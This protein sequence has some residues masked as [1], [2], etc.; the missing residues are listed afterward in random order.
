[1]TKVQIDLPDSVLADWLQA[2]LSKGINLEE[3]LAGALTHTS[4]NS[5]SIASSLNISR[6]S[7]EEL[8]RRRPGPEE[9]SAAYDRGD[10]MAKKTDSTQSKLDEPHIAE[11]QFRELG[12]SKI[13]RRITTNEAN[14]YQDNQHIPSS[15]LRLLPVKIA[16]RAISMKTDRSGNI[17]DSEARFSVEKAL[18]TTLSELKSGAS[19]LIPTKNSGLTAGMGSNT[20]IARAR[21]INDLLGAKGRAGGLMHRL[22]I[23]EQSSTQH[24]LTSEGLALAKQRNPV[25]DGD[26]QQALTRRES[27]AILLLIEQRIPN[28]WKLMSTIAKVAAGSEPKPKTKSKPLA[29]ENVEEKATIEAGG[30]GP[31][32]AIGE[33][34]ETE[35]DSVKLKS[36]QKSAANHAA[37]LAKDL[38]S[39]AEIDEIIIQ[40]SSNESK[41]WTEAKLRT[42]RVALLGRMT[43]LGLLERV[44]VGRTSLFRPGRNNIRLI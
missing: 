2:A 41:E 39:T 14:S 44:W 8:H 30:Q 25:L 21:L 24:R 5:S 37:E 26:A 22:G 6:M 34:S 19:S 33:E 31:E 36:N 13:P 18:K 7:N 38:L 32:E 9:I 27:K 17:N 43:E 1:M 10:S 3:L 23:L 11:Q 28:E 40:K 35:K 29:T 20:D 42:F 4:Q 15:L 12:I 16:I